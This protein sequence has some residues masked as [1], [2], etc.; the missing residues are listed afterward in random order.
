[1]TYS[2]T[3]HTIWDSIGIWEKSKNP[4]GFGSASVAGINGFRETLMLSR[5]AVRDVRVPIGIN[6]AGLRRN[7]APFLANDSESL[8]R[9]WKK[10]FAELVRERANQVS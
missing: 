10:S 3:E 2:L 8:R 6:R 7:S 5:N 4:S 9:I 1:M